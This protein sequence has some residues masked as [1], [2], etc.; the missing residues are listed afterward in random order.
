MLTENNMEECYNRRDQKHKEVMVARQGD[1]QKQ[2]TMVKLCQ[3]TKFN[4][5]I[6]DDNSP[7]R[8]RATHLIVVFMTTCH[9]TR[10]VNL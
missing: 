8:T 2:G 6:D 10:T 7:L 9:N 1:H 5:G 4:D 3:G